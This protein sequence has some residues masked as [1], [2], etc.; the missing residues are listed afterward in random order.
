L[1]ERKKQ[2]TLMTKSNNKHSEAIGKSTEQDMIPYQ[3]RV[4]AITYDNGLKYAQHAKMAQTL[5]TIT[6]FTHPYFFRKESFT[7]IPMD[8]LG[9]IC[10]NQNDST[11]LLIVKLNSTCNF[12]II[13]LD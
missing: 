6:Y 8:S 2:Y 3:N 10:Q 1:G 7:K 13:D 9:N 5:S 12:L 11:T 4:H